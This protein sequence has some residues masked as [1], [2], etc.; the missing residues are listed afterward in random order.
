MK[1]LGYFG[2]IRPSGQEVGLRLDQDGEERLA[3]LSIKSI[4]KQQ[5]TVAAWLTVEEA[6]VMLGW[7]RSFVLTH[8][9]GKK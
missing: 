7:L 5:G 8:E 4:S 1:T 3:C 6:R 2:T 9:K